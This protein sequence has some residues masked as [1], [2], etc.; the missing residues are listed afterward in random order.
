MFDCA[1]G[2]PC[3]VGCCASGRSEMAFPQALQRVLVTSGGILLEFTEYTF[4]HC[5]QMICM[6][7]FLIFGLGCFGYSEILYC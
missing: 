1:G 6:V 4:L 2:A 7:V 5:E 3:G